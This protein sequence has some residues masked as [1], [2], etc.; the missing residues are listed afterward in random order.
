MRPIINRCKLCGETKQLTYEHIP[1]R[2]AFNN[3]RSRFIP[4]DEIVV[5][6]ASDDVPWD[7]SKRKGIIQQRGYGL[8]SLCQGCNSYTGRKYVPA[9]SDFCKQAFEQVGEQGSKKGS[10]TISFKDIYS[11]RIMKEIVCMFLS[12]NHAKFGDRFPELR[13]FVKNYHLRSEIQSA[14]VFAYVNLGIL[15]RVIGNAGIVNISE[16]WGRH[17]S[18]LGTI[19]FG[20]VMEMNHAK[21]RMLVPMVDFADLY[22]IDKKES[23]DVKF[24]IKE[25]NSLLPLDYRTKEEILAQKEKLR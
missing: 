8:H 15:H 4:G 13:E 9:Y 20:Y 11:L 6:I 21:E 17:V 23:I 14:S 19:P 22:E 12:I 2:S 1:P 7:I 18:E 24:P 10:I 3:C 5:H 25:S 16:G